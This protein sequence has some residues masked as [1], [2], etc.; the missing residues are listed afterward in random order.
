MFKTCIFCLLL[1]P[2]CIPASSQSVH[3]KNR[4][5]PFAVTLSNGTRFDNR[6][7][8]VGKPLML[9]YFAPDCDHCRVFIQALRANMK[10]FRHSQILMISYVSVP[11]LNEFY[12]A[13]GLAQFSNVLVASEGNSFLFPAYFKI[14]VFPFIAM[15]SMDHSVAVTFHKTPSMEVLVNW[16]RNIASFAKGK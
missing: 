7:L 6:N 12:K 10:H 8:A 1:L 13:S 16:A 9:V 3:E 11:V 5:P 2:Y 15:F 4:M 14:T